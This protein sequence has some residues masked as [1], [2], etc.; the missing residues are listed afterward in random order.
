M[1]NDSELKDGQ[2]VWAFIEQLMHN[3]FK[4]NFSL[5]LM[6][7]TIAFIITIKRSGIFTDSSEISAVVDYS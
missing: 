7:L 1:S 5:S 6:L 4:F 2:L 3:W